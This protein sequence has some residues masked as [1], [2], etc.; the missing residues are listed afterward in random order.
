M[1]TKR[2]CLLLGFC[3]G[4]LIA[5]TLPEVARAQH[6]L[7]APP[8]AE[9][10]YYYTCRPGSKALVAKFLYDL[11]VRHVL[12]ADDSF[13]VPTDKFLGILDMQKILEPTNPDVTALLEQRPA[14][15][16]TPLDNTTGEFISKGTGPQTLQ[17]ASQTLGIS[18]ELTVP[19]VVQGLYWRSPA[20]LELQFYKGHGIRFHL[21]GTHVT[22]YEEGMQCISISAERARVTT[23]DPLHRYLISL[24]ERCP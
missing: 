3:V 13:D 19:E 4:I 21:S 8:S 16:F 22:E 18:L 20:H 2:R 6:P 1:Q 9:D 15:T 7:C 10:S 12:K 14:I 11:S 17:V 23:A 5:T 24:Y